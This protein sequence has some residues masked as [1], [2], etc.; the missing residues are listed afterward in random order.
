[1]RPLG[2]AVRHVRIHD[3]ADQRG[4]IDALRVAIEQRQREP[5]ER[6]LAGDVQRRAAFPGGSQLLDERRRYRFVRLVVLREGRE[7]LRIPRPLLEHLRRRLVEIALG[8]ARQTEPSLPAGKDVMERVAEFVEH[9]IA[10]QILGEQT[11]IARLSARQA[12]LNHDFRKLP[13]GDALPRRARVRA[14][15]LLVRPRMRV[16]VDAPENRPAVGHL[17]GLDRRIPD[18]HVDTPERHAVH[19]ARDVEH[20]L[21]HA[22][23]REVRTQRLRVEIVV[24]AA[25]ELAVIREIPRRDAFDG[26]HVLLLAPDQLLVFTSGLGACGS[27]DVID[28]IGLRLDASGHRVRHV[29]RRPRLEIEQ[30]GDFGALRDHAIEDRHVLRVADVRQLCVHHPADFFALR[31]REQRRRIGVV[32]AQRDAARDAGLVARDVVGRQPVEIGRARDRNRPAVVVDVGAELADRRVNLAA[33]RGKARARRL[34]LVDA[35]QT[36]RA[37]LARL[38]RACNPQQSEKKGATAG[39]RHRASRP[40]G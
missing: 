32:G 4:R 22:V 35:A 23:V 17:V 25:H 1:M 12:F 2:V 13:P 26:R 15:P 36:K 18:R 10:D 29:V 3:V 30:V 28:E 31:V 34:V 11:R 16:E 38:Q 6:D 19:P 5:R 37:Q 33:Q 14:G 7:R 21:P 8:E 9:R 39:G 40:S 27:D 20:A 24:R